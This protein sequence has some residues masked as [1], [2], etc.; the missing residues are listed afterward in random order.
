MVTVLSFALQAC[1]QLHFGDCYDLSNQKG[2]IAVHPV[3]SPMGLVA[4]LEIWQQAVPL[5]L[6]WPKASVLNGFL[7]AGAIAGWGYRKD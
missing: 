7:A 5:R 6:K 2:P 4:V 3:T 1:G